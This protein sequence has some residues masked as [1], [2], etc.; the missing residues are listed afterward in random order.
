[1]IGCGWCMA[2]YRAAS[3][4]SYE[5][6]VV[7]GVLAA[8]AAASAPQPGDLPLLTPEVMTTAPP[9]AGALPARNCCE[10]DFERQ[11]TDRWLWCSWFCA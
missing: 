10:W 6:G 5:W 1:M 9:V 7:K 8:L 2:G 11:D 3:R 4:L